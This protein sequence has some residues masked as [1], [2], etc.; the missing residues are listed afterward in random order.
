MIHSRS[1]R[2]GTASDGER[3]YPVIGR[4]PQLF[5]SIAAAPTNPI[6]AARSYVRIPLEFIATGGPLVF[7]GLTDLCLLACVVY[8]TAKHRRLHPAFGWGALLIVAS[9]P[10]RLILAGTPAWMRFAT[11]LVG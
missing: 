11:W 8:D 7:F 6:D 10:L 4:N 9:Q 2:P 5:T 3:L 1:K